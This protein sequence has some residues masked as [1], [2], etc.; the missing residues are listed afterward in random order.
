M[1]HKLKY[2]WD[3]IQNYYNKGHSLRDCQNK[4]GFGSTAY[5]KAVKAGRLQLRTHEEACLLRRKHENITPTQNNCSPTTRKGE[6]GCC[7][8]EQRAIEK[9]IIVSRPNL[10]CAYDRIID[11][12]GKLYRAQVKYSSEVVRDVLKVKLTK[13][14]RK[15][16]CR[17]A[18]A[19]N[20]IDVIVVYCSLN[21]K[22]YWLPKDL[23]VNRQA[24]SLRLKNK[25]YKNS[26]DAK[27]YEW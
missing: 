6:M 10:E 22:L 24:I 20:E 9:N 15:R 27:Q 3:E 26:H 18:Y 14:C 2:N 13:T 25:N 17:V 1:P 4:F 19:A 21:D 8:L 23:I 7:K 12:D 16:D 5:S 11:V